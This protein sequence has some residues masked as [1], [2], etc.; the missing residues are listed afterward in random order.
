MSKDKSLSNWCMGI[1]NYDDFNKEKCLSQVEKASKSI[2]FT[3]ELEKSIKDADL[4]IESM[5]EDVTAKR[6]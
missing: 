5:T 4:V 2:K 3:L 1:S 6:D